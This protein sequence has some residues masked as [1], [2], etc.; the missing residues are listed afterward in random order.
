MRE[1]A[2]S[3]GE[4]RRGE[5]GCCREER[6]DWPGRVERRGEERRGEERRGR[7][8]RG[9]EERQSVSERRGEGRQSIAASR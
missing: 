6:R 7:V 9:G 1:G 2:L 8:L 4:E 3:R 5:A